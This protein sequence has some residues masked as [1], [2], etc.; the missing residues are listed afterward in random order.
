MIKVGIIGTHRTTKDT[1]CYGISYQLKKK[2]INVEYLPEIAREAKKMGFPINE[3]T[4]K[5]AQKWILHKQVEKEI[6]FNE[7]VKPDVLITKRS[8]IDNYTYYINRF[9][10]DPS[11][12]GFVY[13]HMNT[14]DLLYK[15][16][17][18]KSRLIDDGTASV[19]PIFQKKID[20][21]LEKELLNNKIPY[22]N[23]TNIEKAVEE[24]MGKMGN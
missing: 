19:D 23:F 8:T 12:E 17:I 15:V 4:T 3:N 21:L 20:V 22:K 2:G 9:G 6:E 7:L 14:Y 18:T 5:N 24:I 13:N 1:I 16:P 10:R 11:L